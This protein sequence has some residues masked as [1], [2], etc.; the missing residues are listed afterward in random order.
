MDSN[1]IKKI[2]YKNKPIAKLK[3]IF[4]DGGSKSY[5][6]K[7]DNIYIEFFVPIK[8][9]NLDKDVFKDEMESQL[10]IR[11]LDLEKTIELNNFLNN[12]KINEKN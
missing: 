9:I 10:L 8:E 11:Y 3:G 1:E 5:I 12:L 6:A 2:L 4:K 7:V